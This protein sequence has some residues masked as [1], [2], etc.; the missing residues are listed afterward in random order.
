MTGETR[1]AAFFFS[2]DRLCNR[3]A[4]ERARGR[5][6]TVTRTAV[7]IFLVLFA[8]LTANV[9]AEE[10]DADLIVTGGVIH[11]LDAASPRVEA[12]AVS[13]GRIVYAGD[14]GGA[15]RYRGEKTRVLDATGLTTLPGLVDAHAHL[16]GLGT[17]LAV[18]DL[19]GAASPDAIRERVLARIAGAGAGEWI[20]GR[21]WDQNDWGVKEFPTWR[22]LGGTESHPVCLR[23]VDGH[24]AWLNRRALE[25][26][27]ITKQTGDPEGGR[28]LRDQEGNPT[29]VLVDNAIELVAGEIPEIS[30]DERVRRL[31]TAVA[32]CLRFGLT[33]V[34]DAGVGEKDLEVLRYLENRGELGLRVYAMI[35]A[36]EP[37][38]ARGQLRRGPVVDEDHFL[39]VRALKLLADGALGSRGAAL[40]DPYTDEPSNR[41][42]IVVSRDE[43]LRWTTS[44]LENGFQ[45]CTHAIGDAGNRLTLDVYEEALSKSGA[46]DSRLRVEHA[47]VLAPDDIAR[48]ARSGVIA[49]VQPT[50]ATSDMAW[51]PDRLGPERIEGAYA[52]RKLLNTGCRIACG[53]DFPVEAVNP[54]WG[55][56]AAVTRK[57]HQGSPEGGWRAGECLSIDE[58]VRGFTV[59][60]A[61]ASFMENSKGTIKPGMLADFTLLDKDVFEISP[62]EIL[63]T[64]VVYTIV[65]GTVSYAA[66]TGA[67]GNK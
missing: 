5:R 30:F 11:T 13:Q 63:S 52:W 17:F 16:A 28:I 12:V 50:H 46:T 58:A 64:R 35:D 18:L 9:F 34:H 49:S 67:G 65:G 10:P 14:R 56:Y 33:G 21:G 23:R 19:N 60:A 2:I 3:A 26:C 25:I 57:D 47:Q 44:A 27:R 37:V 29:G 59:D 41:G 4:Y 48:F 31:K 1:A 42:L 61:F 15:E 43:L 24:A 22:D 32:E 45:V 8:G 53:S 66:P 54:L 7:S 51:A 20:L 40:I 36:D 6:A 62:G 39:D 38:F 55:I